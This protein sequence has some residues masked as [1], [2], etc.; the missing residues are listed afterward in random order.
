M[1]E[2]RELEILTGIQTRIQNMAVEA[3]ALETEARQC[4]ELERCADFLFRCRED[5]KGALSY[6]TETVVR[7]PG[8]P[9]VQRGGDGRPITTKIEPP[10]RFSR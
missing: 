4:L 1:D 3:Q 7:G 6:V 8:R 2:Q 9:L 5:L 10:G